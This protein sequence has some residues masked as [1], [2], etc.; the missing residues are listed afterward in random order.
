V[1]S[2]TA[3]L[4]RARLARDVLPHRPSLVT[5]SAGINDILRGV[6][7]ADYEAEVNAIVERLKQEK[8]PVILLTPSI[9]GPKHEAKEKQLADYIAA[10]RRIAEKH[11]CKIAEVHDAMKQDRA[12]G[13]ECVEPDQVH[14]TFAGYQAM[15]RAVLDA[16]GHKV[17]PVPPELK[18]EMMPGGHRL[19]FPR[20]RRKGSGARRE[21]RTRCQTRRRQEIHAARARSAEAL[22]VRART[23]ARLRPFARQADRR[24]KAWVGVAV[25]EVPTAK[26]VYF[27]TGSGL[28]AAWLNGKRLY[29]NEA[30]TGWHAGKERIAA[31]LQ[32][33]KNFIVIET[34]PQ[35]F[36]SMTEGKD[37]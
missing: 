19:A 31:E 25:I 37:W 23:P 24:R 5:L 11:G 20:S 4:M 30:W 29:R 21:D 17:V 15:A 6:K 14:L 28:N 26:K 32:E 3:A 34:G 18:L 10:L 36:L 33:G 1:A 12:A 7:P 2:D 8:V 16:M 9:L 35:F 27:N 22:V 13:K